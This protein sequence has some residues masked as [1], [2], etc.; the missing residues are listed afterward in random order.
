MKDKVTVDGV[1]LTRA[2]IEA[3]MEELARPDVT[4]DSFQTQDF[5]I[6]LSNGREVGVGN[7]TS[8]PWA[9]KGIYIEDAPRGY[10]WALV[11]NREHFGPNDRSA[12]LIL[13]RIA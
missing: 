5:R 12:T 1:V 9:H 4:V 6:Y 7:R 3:A 8:G 11:S 13:Q 10:E 2:Q